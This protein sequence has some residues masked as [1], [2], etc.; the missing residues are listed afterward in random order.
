MSKNPSKPAIIDSLVLLCAW[1]S[2]KKGIPTPQ[3]H[4]LHER[5]TWKQVV[6]WWECTA[7][8]NRIPLGVENQ[9]VPQ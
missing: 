4:G 3:K 7:C 6:R 9:Y 8:G 5:R 2:E 1:C